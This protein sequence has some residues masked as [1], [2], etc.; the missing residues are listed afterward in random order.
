MTGEFSSTKKPID[1][2]R[3]PWA[4]SGW[5]RFSLDSGRP[6]TP[7]SSGSDGP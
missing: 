4:S 7:S 2:T 6:L 5:M 1:I 3:M